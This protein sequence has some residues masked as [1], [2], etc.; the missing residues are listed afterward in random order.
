M[1]QEYI[2]Y[3]T[4]SDSNF[5]STFVEHHLLPDINFIG[6]SLIKNDISVPKEIINFYIS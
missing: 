4:K 2:E 6:H 5:A 3:I 1:S